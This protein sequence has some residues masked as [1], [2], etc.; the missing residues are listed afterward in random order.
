MIDTNKIM[1]AAS[2]MV[3]SISAQAFT[4]KGVVIDHST[5]EPLIG[6]TVQV[7][8]TTTGVI[9]DIDGRFEI[10]DIKGKSCTL[11]VQYV[12]FKTQKLIVQKEQKEELVIAL[13]P[14]NQ[15]L[16]EVTVVAR[17]NLENERALMMERQK[18][19]VAIENIGAREMS[20]KGISN[21]EEGVK[22]ISGVSVASA[23]QIIVRGLGDRY[24]TTTLNGLPIASPNPDHKLIPLDL[25][26]ASTVKN[27]TVS[28]VYEANTFADYSGAH[29][30]I[31]TKEQT[32]EDF[33]A[34]R[35]IPEGNSIP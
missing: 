17:K 28:K 5:K 27:I 8:G 18:S 33:S 2:A 25:F 1:L 21:V 31:G 19:S 12:S 9:T 23:G 14:D 24:S 3:L 30:D 20:A 29:I 32:G 4:V 26:P 34:C 7:E 16:D 15:Q 11:V 22:K 6:A 10:R 13:S 35:S